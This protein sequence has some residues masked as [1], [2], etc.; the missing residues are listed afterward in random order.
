[1]VCVV[2]GVVAGEDGGIAKCTIRNFPAIILHCIE[3]AREM[4]DEWFTVLTLM[5]SFA[6]CCC[7]LRLITYHH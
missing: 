5:I 1:M 2:Q 6:A 4:F 7:H 3:W